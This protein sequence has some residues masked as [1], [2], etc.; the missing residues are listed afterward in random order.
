VLAIVNPAAGRGAGERALPAIRAIAQEARVAWTEA[1][2]EE[3]R[4]AWKIAEQAARDSYDIVVAMGGDG[5][6]HE[7]VNGILRGR[8]D[9]PPAL[10]VIPAGT[11]NIFARALDLPAHP[12][13]AARVLVNGVRRRIDV[14]QVHDRYFATIVVPARLVPAG[15]RQHRLVRR[16]RP[17]RAARAR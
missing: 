8:P 7:V 5:T 13:A 6:L 14:G 12:V 3:P 17:H 4:Q 11:A 1:I 15:G 10:A 16:R 9:N 2:A